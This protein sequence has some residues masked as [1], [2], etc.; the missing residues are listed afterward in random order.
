VP[1]ALLVLVLI[2]A[3]AGTL[4]LVQLSGGPQ[5]MPADAR[6]DA[7][8]LPVVVHIVSGL[9]F[10]VA[11]AFQFSA[12]LRRRRRSWHRRAGRV[13]V[14]A[15]FAAALSALWMTLLYARE[16][17]TGE[18]AYLARLA[19]GSGLAACLILGFTAIRRGDVRH[20]RAWMMRAY[21][22]ALGAGTQALTQGVGSAV[23]GTSVL[24]G[25]LALGA[26]WAINLAVAEL[27]IRRRGR[28]ILRRTPAGAA[29]RTSHRGVSV[30]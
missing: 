28:S 21:A 29:P 1:F 2:P 6:M 25:D 14:A 4:R 11:G 12:A 24:V 13:L 15:G 20:H 19:F 22:L 27:L 23:F 7:S 3:V 8:P 9:L 16:P 26:G 18:I 17:G 5:L 10:V 30:P